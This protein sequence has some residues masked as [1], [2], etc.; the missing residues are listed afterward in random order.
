MLEQTQ[1]DQF[2]HE[3]LTYWTVKSLDR[4]FELHGL[5]IFHA[6]RLAIHGGSLELL[7]AR[8]GVRAVDASGDRLRAE[9]KA[10][11]TT[12]SRPIAA[13]L[14]AFGKWR[15][16]DG[17]PPPIPSAGKRLQAFGAPAKGATLLNSFKI[18]PEIIE[19]AV[20]VNPMKI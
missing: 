13:S 15:R 6:D 10:A 12:N 14:A 11:G 7:V 4:L 5:E 19:C 3:H 2:Y 20:K 8:K 9:E 17:P 1:F 16:A 18:S